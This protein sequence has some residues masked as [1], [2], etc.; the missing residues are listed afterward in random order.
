MANELSKIEQ[1]I[2]RLH[3]QQEALLAKERPE[4]LAQINNLIQL[5]QIAPKEIRFGPPKKRGRKPGS[6]PW[7]AL[8]LTKAEWVDQGQPDARPMTP[9]RLPRP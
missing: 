8:G 9:F 3:K 4:A 6:R 5:Y 7:Q 2:A 1:E